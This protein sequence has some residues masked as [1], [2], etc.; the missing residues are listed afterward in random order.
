MTPCEAVW[1]GGKAWPIQSREAGELSPRSTCYYEC[2]FGG[3]ST[4]FKLFLCRPE[5]ASA[6]VEFIGRDQARAKE[7]W[8]MG[9]ENRQESRQVELPRSATWPWHVGWEGVGPGHCRHAGPTAPCCH[10]RPFPLLA[11]GVWGHG[12]WAQGGERL[13]SCART[14]QFP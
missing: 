12:L 13:K 7:A 2:C 4:L 3:T 9:L 11:G 14:A 5:S 1:A 10:L 8:C 6:E